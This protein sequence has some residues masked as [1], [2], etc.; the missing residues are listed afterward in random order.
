MYSPKDAQ[1][2]Y[3]HVDPTMIK[4]SLQVVMIA[5]GTTVERKLSLA[6][7]EVWMEVEARN[8]CCKPLGFSDHDFEE[9]SGLPS[10]V[11]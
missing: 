11:P 1:D 6:F 10:S 5:Q 4:R 3:W 8:P 9:V 2:W 7:L